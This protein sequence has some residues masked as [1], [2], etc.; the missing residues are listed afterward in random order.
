M[1]EFTL[2]ADNSTSF[3]GEKLTSQTCTVIIEGRAKAS[4][5]ADNAINI[6]AKGRSELT[7]YDSPD[8]NIVEFAD[9]ASLFK[10]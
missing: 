9:Q 7:I 6:T 8:F 2:R 3:T 1:K 10:K 5:K 4:V